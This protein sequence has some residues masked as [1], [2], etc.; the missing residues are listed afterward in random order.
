[1]TVAVQ[2]PRQKDDTFSKLAKGLQIASSVLGL[3]DQIFGKELTPEQQKMHDLKMQQTET[4][5]KVDEA[6]LAELQAK[7]TERENLQKG[8]LT[9]P[10]LLSTAGKFKRGEPGAEGSIGTFQTPAGEK[11]SLIPDQKKESMSTYQ[12][13]MLGLARLKDV[14][15]ELKDEEQKTKTKNESVRKISD[16]VNK[17]GILE[18]TNALEKINKKIGIDIDSDIPGVGLTGVAA[19][20]PLVGGVFET[21]LSDEGKEVRQLVS[22][23]R[24][25][26]LKARSGGAV[27][28]GE[29]ARLLEEIGLGP[30]KTDEQLRIGLRLVRDTLKSKLQ[31]IEAGADPDALSEYRSRKGSISSEEELFQGLEMMIANENKA[32]VLPGESQAEASGGQ[33][34]R[35]QQLEQRLRELEGQ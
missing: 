7:A 16:A 17:S 21:M 2:Q 12:R 5:V 27:S 31:N 19:S 35:Q 33:M 9:A 15:A 29:A 34:T 28:D 8:I 24:N 22:S 3:K 10:Q 26:V 18:V 30:N 4:G 1:M 32:G 13:E 11:F 23:V 6:Q 20:L 14:R 25:A